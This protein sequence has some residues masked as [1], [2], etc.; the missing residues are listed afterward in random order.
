MFVNGCVGTT[1]TALAV[2]GANLSNATTIAYLGNS[3][4]QSVP[5]GNATLNAT[6]TGVGSLG[7]V[8]ANL[9]ANDNYSVFECGTVLADSIIIVNDAMPAASATYAYVRLVNTSSDTSATAITG[10]V[11]NTVVGSNIA[12]A[13]AS[14]WTQ[15][16]PG[17]YSLTAFNVNEPGN[18]ATLS[19]T[20]VNSGKFY[21]LLY[22]GN[23][24]P[25]VGF[26]LTVINNN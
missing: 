23:S 20:Q 8:T 9:T 22:S 26:K 11:G 2:N 13:A 18:I 16:T 5:A 25:S 7:S 1:S 15:V 3:G 14:G 17:S 4:Y 21:T 19:A 12:Y 6:L 10:A 24:T